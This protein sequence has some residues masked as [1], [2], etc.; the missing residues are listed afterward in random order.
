MNPNQKAKIQQLI[1]GLDSTTIAS[2]IGVPVQA[3]AAVRAHMTMGTYGKTSE[4]RAQII[5]T[6][7][8]GEL[9]ISTLHHGAAI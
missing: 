5:R 7:N 4:S 8:P 9:T 1:E 3:V 6:R 2:Q